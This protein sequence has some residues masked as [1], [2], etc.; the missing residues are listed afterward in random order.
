[1]KVISTYIISDFKKKKKVVITTAKF[2]WDNN[3]RKFNFGQFTNFNA[4]T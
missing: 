1:M 4:K 2:V 3:C